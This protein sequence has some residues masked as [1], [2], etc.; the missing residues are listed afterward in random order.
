MAPKTLKDRERQDV[1]TLMDMV[2]GDY[3]VVLSEGEE[4]AGDEAAQLEHREVVAACIRAARTVCEQFGI[5]ADKLDI[6]SVLQ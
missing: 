2:I 4:F 3:L 1:A 6:N 5:D